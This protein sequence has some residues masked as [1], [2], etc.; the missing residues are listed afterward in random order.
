[1][2][3]VAAVRDELPEFSQL[4]HAIYQ[5][6]LNPALWGGILAGMA[7]WLGAE[8]AV[9][10]TPLHLPEDGG[11]LFNHEFPPSTFEL[12][13]TRYRQDDPWTQAGVER[14]FFVSGNVATG[15]QLVP[16][17]TLV[18]SRWYRE[19]MSHYDVGQLLTGIVFGV[20]SDTM[21][22]V[23]CSFFRSLDSPTFGDTE[24]ARLE[25]LVPHLSAALAVRQRL[26]LADLRVASSFAA[27][28]C[29]VHG[30]LLMRQDGEILFANGA[31][32]EIFARHGGLALSSLGTARIVAAPAMQE[33]ISA[34]LA[35]ALSP[36]RH[37]AAAV[38]VPG[39]AGQG[40]V[41]L[42]FTPL[43]EN[44]EY[45][46]DDRAPVAMV[47]VKDTALPSRLD[48]RLVRQVLG[49]SAAETRVALAHIDNALVVD[50]ADALSIS[51]NTVKTHLKQ[52]YAKLNI[53]SRWELMRALSALSM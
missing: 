52:I 6:A 10:V 43:A 19:F 12:W 2:A 26:R 33:A 48:P 30:V 21:L 18:A 29:L 38:H 34:A 20:E 3:T 39:S 8:K 35:A 32:R 16:R 5:G 7:R 25:L 45:L 24:R 28:D 14:N 50:I 27:L 40:V 37:A 31:C 44:S 46:Y 11:F 41:V 22:P 15:D 53:G 13:R 51:P 36:G 49:L 1:M 4:I 9:I 17:A 23:V 47:F 42:H